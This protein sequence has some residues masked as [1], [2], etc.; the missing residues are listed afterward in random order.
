MCCRVWT[1][2]GCPLLAWISRTVPRL[3]PQTLEVQPASLW[4]WMWISGFSSVPFS[5]SLART[6]GGAYEKIEHALKLQR[7]RWVLWHIWGGG[8]WRSWRL[9]MGSQSFSLSAFVFKTPSFP[10]FHHLCPRSHIWSFKRTTFPFGINSKLSRPF[11]TSSSGL[12]KDLSCPVHVTMNITSS[13]CSL[14]YGCHCWLVFRCRQQRAQRSCGTAS[15]KPGGNRF[16]FLKW[17]ALTLLLPPSTH[18][19]SSL[20]SSL[21]PPCTSLVLKLFCSWSGE[22]FALMPLVF[23]WKW[24]FSPPVIL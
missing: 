21:L 5:T 7:W 13:L 8:I 24:V 4:T 11:G 23:I 14:F 9:Q 12:D 22:R 16:P 6:P 10:F 3:P 20:L 1:C 15:G 18:H 17:G 19:P 2:S